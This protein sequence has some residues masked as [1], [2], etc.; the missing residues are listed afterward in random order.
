MLGT[1]NIRYGSQEALEW[2][3]N[4]LLYK[5]QSLEIISFLNSAFLASTYG[6][7]WLLYKTVEDEANLNYGI[8]I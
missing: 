7:K 5:L 1:R 8:F 4:V 3:Q 2:I 6:Q